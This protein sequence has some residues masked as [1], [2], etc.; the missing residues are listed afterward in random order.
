MCHHIFID[1]LADHAHTLSVSLC[2]PIFGSVMLGVACDRR[3]EKK[4]ERHNHTYMQVVLILFY[5]SHVLRDAGCRWGRQWRESGTTLFIPPPHWVLPPFFFCLVPFFFETC[6]LMF[7]VSAQRAT[8]SRVRIRVAVP[9]SACVAGQLE[10]T[11]SSHGSS[12]S[13]WFGFP[14][15]GTTKAA[16][17]IAMCRLKFPLSP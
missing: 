11:Q 15:L 7:R 17:N 9:A 10:K 6:T 12:A 5:P 4:R 3:R 16:T 8:D 14:P 1:L 13:R 2:V